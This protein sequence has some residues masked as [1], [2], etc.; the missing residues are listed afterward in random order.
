M[1]GR[2]DRGFP[3][4]VR[5]IIS[6][7]PELRKNSCD[8]ILCLSPK[9]SK[10]FEYGYFLTAWI[11]YKSHSTLIIYA[12][13]WHSVCGDLSSKWIFFL[14][15][16]L[17]LLYRMVS[18]S[19]DVGRGLPV[20]NT[21]VS[22]Q[23]SLSI[24]IEQTKYDSNLLGRGEK[25]LRFVSSLGPNLTEC[26]WEALNKL[27]RQS[28][29]AN[30]RFSTCFRFSSFSFSY[31]RRFYLHFQSLTFHL[32]SWIWDMF[33][34]LFIR[35]VWS[36]SSNILLGLFGISFQHVWDGLVLV[37]LLF[38]RSFRSVSKRMNFSFG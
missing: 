9:K 3:L 12:N 14:K 16:W 21:V 8:F 24:W 10:V 29:G 2:E 22:R 33:G 15:R 32:F 34:D 38:L 31:L 23:H 27:S 25:E 13:T 36:I 11:W 30:T 35:D 19:R 28:L 5:E 17:W 6:F 26:E 7:S 1:K 37:F 20:W 4:F 18:G